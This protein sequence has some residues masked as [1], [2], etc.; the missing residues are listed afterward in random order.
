M[1]GCGRPKKSGRPGVRDWLGEAAR[2]AHYFPGIGDP[3]NLTLGQWDGLI[4]R[5][6]EMEARKVPVESKQFH[7]FNL[8]L[9]K[10]EAA[11]KKYHDGRIAKSR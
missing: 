7:P 6:L 1:G 8:T 4:S 11:R 3:F 9:T 10:L 5:M 2:I